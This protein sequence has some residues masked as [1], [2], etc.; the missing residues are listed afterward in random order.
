MEIEIDKRFNAA[1]DRAKEFLDGMKEKGDIGQYVLLCE[2][3]DD[4]MYMCNSF[5]ASGAAITRML[6]AFSQDRG[7]KA[8]AIALAA[9][10]ISN[11]EFRTHT[12]Y[13]LSNPDKLKKLMDEAMKNK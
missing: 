10:F 8:A 3:G 5:N 4:I 11:E 2:K 9:A 7:L 6:Y 1:L 13:L 12:K